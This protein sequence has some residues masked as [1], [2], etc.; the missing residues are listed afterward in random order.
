MTELLV[1]VDPERVIDLR[2]RLLRPHQERT[3]AIY[4]EDRD[5]G[6]RH[7]LLV[8]DGRAVGCSSVY[9]EALDPAHGLR[10]RGMAVEP[11]CRGQG[12]GRLLVEALQEH[13]R[14]QGTGLWCN[15]RTTAGAFYESVGLCGH[16]E[17][18]DLRPLGPHRIYC[19][20][21]PASP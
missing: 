13:A 17:V 16:G 21:P 4:P 7:W 20:R 19:W 5:P 11:D 18:F 12:L 6:A 15:A 8:Q 2:H 1:D 9:A 14:E 3:A 10:F